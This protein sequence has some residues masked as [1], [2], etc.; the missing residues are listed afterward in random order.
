MKNQISLDG[1]LLLLRLKVSKLK[2]II[3]KDYDD[4]IKT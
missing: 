3:L 2:V 1:I 4:F